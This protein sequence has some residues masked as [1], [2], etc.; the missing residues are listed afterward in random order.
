MNI[1]IVEDGRMLRISTKAAGADFLFPRQTL[2]TEFV[3]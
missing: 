3:G 1:L 2:C